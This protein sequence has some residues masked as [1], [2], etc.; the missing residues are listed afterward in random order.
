MK[1]IH[2]QIISGLAASICLAVFSYGT[3]EN[4]GIN[5][6]MAAFIGF[7]TYILLPQEPDPREVKLDLGI[8]QAQLNEALGRI[9]DF[10]N[11]YNALSQRCRDEWL[12]EVIDQIVIFL[13]NIGAKFKKD[14]KDLHMPCT[15]LFMDQYMPRSYRLFSDYVRLW[16]HATERA[17]RANLKHTE[18]TAERVISGYAAFY[19]HCLLDGFV[20][21]K[22]GNETMKTILETDLAPYGA[23]EGWKESPE[24]ISGPAESAV[25]R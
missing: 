20:D 6:L 23:A 2:R 5:L 1:E 10:I 13:K 25:G 9:D 22:A 16:N 12:R 11:E 4:F 7:A 14:P 19:R 24:R 3:Q 17:V 8:S 15:T 18:V 21:L